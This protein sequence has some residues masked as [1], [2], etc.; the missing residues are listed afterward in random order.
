MIG[1]KKPC[2]DV[3]R[4][5]ADA[6]RV[7]ET[8]ILPRRQEN[9]VD[10]AQPQSAGL[11]GCRVGQDRQ[12]QISEWLAHPCRR[13]VARHHEIVSHGIP[14]RSRRTYILVREVNHPAFVQVTQKANWITPAAIGR[15]TGRWVRKDGML[16]RSRQHHP[17][18]IFE[19]ARVA[20][21]ASQ[22]RA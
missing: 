16:N 12:I 10:V 13:V 17:T 6:E 9:M 20:A 4:R 14:V 5:V 2:F 18:L 8:G 3:I 22:L 1:A 11:R 21:A 19:I 7:I 15:A